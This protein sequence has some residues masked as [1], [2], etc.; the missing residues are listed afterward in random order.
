[1][2]HPHGRRQSREFRWAQHVAQVGEFQQGRAPDRRARLREGHGPRESTR[3]DRIA[4]GPQ[5]SLDLVPL[6]AGSL[7][8]DLGVGA[9][10]G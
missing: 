4:A 3:L 6:G 9:D 7:E 8:P 10:V 2:R 5:G 1:M